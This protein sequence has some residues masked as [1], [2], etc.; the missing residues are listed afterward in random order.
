M[1]RLLSL[2]TALLLA[3]PCWAGDPPAALRFESLSRSRITTNTGKA[4]ATDDGFND[5]SR[6][7]LGL[8]PS[9]PDRDWVILVRTQP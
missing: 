6:Q 8:P 4:S 1:K 3:P 7:D 9:D 5:T 2:L